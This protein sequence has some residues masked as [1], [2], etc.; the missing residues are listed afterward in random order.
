M[1]VG[2]VFMLLFVMSYSLVELIK[3]TPRRVGCV[4]LS[5][6]ENHVYIGS[7]GCV[8]Q[9]NVATDA[10]VKFEGYLG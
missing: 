10:V 8:L 4:S 6:H 1:F 2:V 3:Q 9:W 5:F 7:E